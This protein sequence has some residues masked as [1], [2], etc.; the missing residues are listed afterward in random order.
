MK[1]FV[2]MMLGTA[3]LV[4][5]SPSASVAQSAAPSYTA[6]PSVYKVIFED[7]NLRVIAVDRKKGVFDKLHSHLLSG[8]V[9]NITDC[10]TKLAS[11]DGKSDVRDTK[12]GTVQATPVTPGH[13]AENIGTEDCKQILVEKK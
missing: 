3:I 2:G 11:P 9:Y 1:S 8:I 12:A 6:D 7:A 4:G 10:K 5:L 13:T